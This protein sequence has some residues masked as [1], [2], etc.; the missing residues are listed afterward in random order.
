MWWERCQ[1]DWGHCCP[2]RGIG[3]TLL[4]HLDPPS[5]DT[6]TAGWPQ[7]SVFLQQLWS[8]MF[9]LCSDL[10]SQG[11]KCLGRLVRKNW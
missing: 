2:G 9:L 11:D 8:P 5:P 7:G 3:C 6:S 4:T 1:A 10:P